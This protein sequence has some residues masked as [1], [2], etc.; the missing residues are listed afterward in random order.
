MALITLG[1]VIS[2]FVFL[3]GWLTAHDKKSGRLHFI[4]MLITFFIGFYSLRYLAST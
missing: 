1:Y 4:F 2:F 3:I